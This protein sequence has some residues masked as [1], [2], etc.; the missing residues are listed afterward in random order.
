MD[1]LLLELAKLQR[2]GNLKQS[3]EDVDKI[4]EQ[5]EKARDTIVAGKEAPPTESEVAGS[6]ARLI[7][8][9]ADFFRSQLCL[10]YACE[11]T[12]STEAWLR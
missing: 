3:I 12:E 5:L 2:D 1:P 9:I 11:T 10:Y 4:I 8:T 7:V 6:E